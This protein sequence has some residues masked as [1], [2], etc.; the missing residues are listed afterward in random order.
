MLDQKAVDKF[1][2]IYEER[3]EHPLTPTE[4]RVMGQNLVDLYLKIYAVIPE[5]TLRAL[6]NEEQAE[7]LVAAQS[8][9]QAVSAPESAASQNQIDDAGVEAVSDASPVE[10]GVELPPS[11]AALQ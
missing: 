4:A 10:A 7:K 9:E 5:E 8:Q 2:L 1:R 6:W 11:F 3:F